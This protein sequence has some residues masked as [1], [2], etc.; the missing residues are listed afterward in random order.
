MKSP[1]PICLERVRLGTAQLGPWGHTPLGSAVVDIDGATH[2]VAPLGSSR[3]RRFHSVSI[4][5]ALLA[6]VGLVGLVDGGRIT[7]AEPTTSAAEASPAAAVHDQVRD[8]Q[9]DIV[10]E[11][12]DIERVLGK[13]K[14]ASELA[15]T[16]MTEAAGKAEVVSNRLQANDPQ[17][18]ADA[19]DAKQMFQE[20]S[21]QLEAMLTE[22]TPQQVAAARTMAAQLAR[23]EREFL[24][25]FPGALNAFTTGGIGNKDPKTIE[26]ADPDGKKA[27]QPKSIGQ[28][29]KPQNNPDGNAGN[30]NEGKEKDAG[31]S[32]AE[33]E[34]QGEQAKQGV[35]TPQELAQKA[36]ELAAR[37]K[38]LLDLLESVRRSDDPKDQ[39]ATKAIDEILK[40][41]G[42]EQALANLEKSAEQ[43]AAG[44]TESAQLAAIDAADRLELVASQLERVYRDLVS[45]QAE[46][47]RDLEAQL[48]S[49]LE[50]SQSLETPRDVAEW[51]REARN[52]V[53]EA[54]K[55]GI[56]EELTNPAQQ[57]LSQVPSGSLANASQQLGL[58][59]TPGGQYRAP[60][61]IVNSL[62]S[63]HEEVQKQLQSLALRDMASYADEALPP[64]YM[65]LVDKYY[66]VLSGQSN[67][68]SI[69]QLKK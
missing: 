38:T 26:F 1:H 32:A 53:D 20:I 8:Q 6:A 30:S 59:T 42:L 2:V 24:E 46:E 45:P 43:I 61:Q 14:R 69:E 40:A 58:W 27:E 21:R 7:A 47:L 64:E 49:L 10:L 65:H 39:A 67:D 19:A 15:K 60:T 12:R 48:A 56:S 34:K 11:A 52:A 35:M 4:N 9:L 18:R 31:D 13:I 55:A 51:G 44:D 29:G 33:E 5:I 50:Q 22:D 37:A 25:Q 41:S 23:L 3:R 36:K 16:R 17:V 66:E 57:E 62:R 68:T 63:L 28:A 54:T